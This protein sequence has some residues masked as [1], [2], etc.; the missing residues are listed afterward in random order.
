[1][2]MKPAILLILLWACATASIYS[3][4][5]SRSPISISAIGHM[6]VTLLSPAAI[7]ASQNLEFND[8]Q[9]R[10]AQNTSGAVDCDMSM[11]SVR[12]SGTQATYAVTVSNNQMGFNQNGNTLSIGNF[13]AVSSEEPS[14]SSSVYIGATM[15]IQK[16]KAVAIAESSTPLTITINYN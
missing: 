13:S 4:V 5:G 2:K 7:T 3:Q 11:A 12:V 1:M 9:L 16:R 14:G 6:S 8:I 15:S 10:S